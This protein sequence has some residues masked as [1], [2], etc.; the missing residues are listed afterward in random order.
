MRPSE[1]LFFGV[2]FSLILLFFFPSIGV[3]GFLITALSSVLIDIDH[4]FY[5]VYK[6]K[7]LS[8]I[9]AYQ[10]YIQSGKKF[11]TLSQE[12][13]KKVYSGFYILHG[14]EILFVLFLLGIYFYKYFLFVFIGF[15][16]HL[17]LDLFSELIFKQRIDKLSVIYDFL[18]FRKI[19]SIERLF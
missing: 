15:L 13:K 18:K 8:L 7:N 5:F 16:I 10:W 14:V 3:L 17:S 9:K 1:H 12:Q 19:I 4:Y 2:V 6:K 11:D